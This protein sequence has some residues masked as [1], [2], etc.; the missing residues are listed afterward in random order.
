MNR[1]KPKL[2]AEKPEFPMRINKYLANKKYCT[3]RAADKLVTE[4]KVLINGNTAVLGDKVVESDNVEVRFHAKRYRYFAYYKPR[5]IVTH[6]AQGEDEDEITDIVPIEGVF[7]LGRLDK[8][9]YG[10]ILLTDDG[11]ITDALLNPKYEH[12]KE[13][14]VRCTM[15][16][17]AD[18]KEK[19]EAG[20]DIGSYTTKLCHVQVWADSAFSIT[21]TEGKKHQIRKM[22]GVFGLNPSELQ[23]VRIMNIK[24]GS[25]MPGAYRAIK[26]AE[27]ETFLKSIGF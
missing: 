27:L 10:L 4:G 16:L 2:V 12:E 7:P 20:I 11:R 26:G 19:M 21:L 8:D 9:S 18:F 3:R 22:C 15:P 17:P 14:K 1:P 6:S 13:Y 24:I 25:L 23:R 5:G